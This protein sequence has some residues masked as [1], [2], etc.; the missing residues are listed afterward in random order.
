MKFSSILSGM[1]KAQTKKTTTE[2]IQQDLDNLH[3]NLGGGTF[4]KVDKIWLWLWYN[5]VVLKTTTAIPCILR[6]EEDD[7]DMK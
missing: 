2:Y 5:R 7:D 1:M 3:K 6:E 4:S